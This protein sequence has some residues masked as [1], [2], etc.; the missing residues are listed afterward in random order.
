MF[1]R[2]GLMAMHTDTEDSSQMRSSLP[3]V[4][5]QRL[6]TETHNCREPSESVL[7]IRTV[8]SSL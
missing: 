5:E 2:S 1:P 7:R 6:V 4:L 3:N 8:P